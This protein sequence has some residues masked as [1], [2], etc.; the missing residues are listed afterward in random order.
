MSEAATGVELTRELPDKSATERLARD[1]A[2]L[3]APGDLV[4]LDG[5]L[6]AGKT[7]FARALARALG[8]PRGVRVT[9]PTF[10]LVHEYET[11]PRLLHADLYR[12]SDDE[13]GVYELGLLPQR[14]DGALLV[15]EWGLPF[16]RLLGGDALQLRL[17]REPRKAQVSASGARS[18]QVLEALARIGQESG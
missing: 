1:L 13:R 11:Q 7:F 6:G 4:L 14:D 9:S 10:T 18:R 15:V 5:P 8:L 3:L 17:Q 12:L 2:P 16:E